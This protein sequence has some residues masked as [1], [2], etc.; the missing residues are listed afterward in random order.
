MLPDWMTQYALPILLLACSAMFAF[1][2]VVYC[3]LR[4]GAQAD[5]RS[6]MLERSREHKPQ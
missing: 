4:L 6:E 5:E 2:F 1:G 3:A